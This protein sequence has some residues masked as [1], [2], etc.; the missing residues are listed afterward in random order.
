MLT[1]EELKHKPRELLPAT[2][3]KQDE[4]ETLLISFGRAYAQAY[5][6]HQTIAGQVR[7]RGKRQL[8]KFD[9]FGPY[10]TP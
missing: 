3:L 10:P 1:Y 4:F 8:V 7:Q 5:Q 6:E 9:L 2:S